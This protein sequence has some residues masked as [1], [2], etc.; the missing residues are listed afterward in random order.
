[1][2]IVGCD[3]A[4]IYAHNSVSW[5]GL[6]VGG[7]IF[8]GP[9]AARRGVPET[10]PR[11]WMQACCHASRPSTS[12]LPILIMTL[13]YN[14]KPGGVLIPREYQKEIFLKAQQRNVIAVLDTGSGKTLISALLIKWIATQEHSQ[15]KVTVFLVPKVP[16][17]EQQSIF[18]AQHTSLRVAQVH[19]E[20]SASVT[21]HAR[22]SDLFSQADVLVMTGERVSL[23][24][25]FFFLIESRA[26]FL[27]RTHPLALE[28]EQGTHILR[29]FRSSG[30]LQRVL[31]FPSCPR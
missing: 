6:I 18:I 30:F 25:A 21:D 22:W 15:K 3:L 29:I 13:V 27:K 4:E 14:P 12:H 23:W 8:V 19:S 31:G 7:D 9:D 16:L 28:Y 1:L 24:P 17:V 26:D 20:V 5:F 2:Y 10:V 11:C